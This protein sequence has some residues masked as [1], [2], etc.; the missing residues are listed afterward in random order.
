M[1]SDYVIRKMV[2]A[3]LE[4]S[5]QKKMKE[6][7]RIVRSQQKELKEFVLTR[8]DKPS[9]VEKVQPDEIVNLANNYDS[10]YMSIKGAQ[11]WGGLKRSWQGYKIGKRLGEDEGDVF[12][13]ERQKECAV[14]VQELQ[15]LLRTDVDEFKCLEG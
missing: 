12:E 1:K 8:K 10:P 2:Q 11:L 7:N 5:L 3:R 14:K 15:K 9:S 4:K 6:E 13:K